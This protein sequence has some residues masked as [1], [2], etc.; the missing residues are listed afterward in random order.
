TSLLAMVDASFG[1][2]TAINV[3]GARNL[4]G[5]FYPAESVTISTAFLRSLPQR[6]YLSGLAELVKYAMLGDAG[7][8]H[9]LRQQ[10]AALLARQ[11]D[12][13]ALH[14]IR[15][16]LAVK[17]RFTG[18]DPA[19][20]GARACLNLGHTFG[21]GLEAAAGFGRFTHGEAVAWGILRALDA[22][23]ELGITDCGYAEGAARFFAELGFP[24]RAQRV[25]ADGILAAMESDKKGR[26]GG[27]A[28]F[29]SAG[30]A[31]P[32]PKALRPPLCGKL[33]SAA[34][35]SA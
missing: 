4:V 24:A 13:A 15:R 7:L 25:S 11:D 19:E 17:A 20:T 23:R 29:S 34:S 28:L 8:Y 16:G 9:S 30:C 12:G 2:K 6:E 35:N 10:G 33:W 22:G 21:H 26:R 31:T 1:G 32:S 18:E 3:A 14:M 5:T 27:C